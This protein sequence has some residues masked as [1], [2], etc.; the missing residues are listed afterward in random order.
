MLT[1]SVLG[2][3][4]TPIM[5]IANFGRS[6]SKDTGNKIF[7]AWFGEGNQSTNEIISDETIKSLRDG[8][9]FY[10]YQNGIPKI[11]EALSNY[12]NNVFGLNL[13]PENN[14]LVTG[15]MLGI[16]IICDML[17]DKD[18]SAERDIK[19]GL[20]N[21]RAVRKDIGGKGIANLYWVPRGKPRGISPKTPSDVIIQ[22]TDGTFRGYSNKISAGK[23]ETPKFNTNV[24]AFY[25][26]MGNFSQLMNVQY[27]N[28]LFQH[29]LY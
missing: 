9:T 21:A 24:N 13:S 23:D 6:Y 8:K 14:S 25:K 2:I 7:A 26:E 5:E 28:Y 10:T 12:M 18:E 1:K 15:G 11:R 27:L 20:N 3:K 29:F 22:F 17:I 19:I 4:E 16:K